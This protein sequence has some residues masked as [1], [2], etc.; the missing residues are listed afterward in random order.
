MPTN[1]PPTNVG[2]LVAKVTQ[3]TT[4]IAAHRAAMSEVAAI[5]VAR[6]Q[7]PPREVTK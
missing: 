5:A 6:K 3:A 7:E 2:G 1:E 4:N